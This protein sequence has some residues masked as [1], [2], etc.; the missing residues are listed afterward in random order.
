MYAISKAAAGSAESRAYGPAVQ[1][2]QGGSAIVGVYLQLDGAGAT[3]MM[4]LGTT[5]SAARLSSSNLY[6]ARL[7]P[8]MLK[9]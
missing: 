4:L 9:K 3:L 6:G 1:L 8:H 7:P 2:A 5:K